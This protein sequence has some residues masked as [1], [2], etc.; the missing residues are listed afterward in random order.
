[1]F[2]Y[3]TLIVFRNSFTHFKSPPLKSCEPIPAVHLKLYIRP[4]SVD[5]SPVYTFFFL[6]LFSGS[7]S[8]SICR[9]A[10]ASLSAT[11]PP[12]A[13]VCHMQCR[14]YVLLT[15]LSSSMPINHPNSPNP[16]PIGNCISEMQSNMQRRRRTPASPSASSR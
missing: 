15:L 4:G 13:T 12:S 7:L 14:H 8:L 6:A 5:P 1:M 10:A 11:A 2:S 16:P 3:L 9:D